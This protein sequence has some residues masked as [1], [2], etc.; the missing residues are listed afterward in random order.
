VNANPKEIVGWILILIVPFASAT[1]LAGAL[2]LMPYETMVEIVK[3]HFAAVIGLP[4]AAIFSA[5]IVVALQQTSGPVKFEG[6][7]FK[8]EG[9]SGQV[10]LWVFRF[11]AISAAI[12]LLWAAWRPAGAD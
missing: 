10:V 4:T 3:E 6:L 5:F 12:K 9:S 7:S 11:L 2:S 8:F 1:A